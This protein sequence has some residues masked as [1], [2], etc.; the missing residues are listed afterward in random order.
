VSYLEPIRVLV[1]DDEA[2][3][4]RLAEK[5]LALPHREIFTARTASQAMKLV[6]NQ[7]FDV[8]LLDIRLPDGDGQDLLVKFRANLPNVEIIMITGY[9][10]VSGA[11]EA[12]KVGAYDY[13]TKPFSL[14]K[15]NS[16]IE[17]AYQQ[18]ALQKENKENKKDKDSESIHQIIG[19]SIAMRQTRYLIKKVAKTK[20][21]VLVT[22]ETGVGKDVVVNLIHNLSHLSEKPLVVKNCGTFN[23]DLLRNELFGH[24]KGSFT[25]AEESQ[26]GLIAAADKSSLFLDEIGEL[27]HE[28]QSML[29]RI[30]E[31]KKYRRVGDKGERQADVRFFFATN[32]DLSVEVENGNFNE[33]LFHRINV[34]RIDVPP[35]RERKED[36]PALIEYFLG[37]LHPDQSKYRMSKDAWQYFLK[38]NW[39]GNVR[40]LKNVIERSIIL[41]ENDLITKECLPEKMIRD[42]TEGNTKIFPPLRHKEKQYILQVLNHTNYNKSLAADMLGIGR[43]TL[44]RKLKE[45]RIEEQ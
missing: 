11:V 5:E 36:L 14:T 8:I 7:P 43:K 29:L 40:E 3:I 12:M 41:A 34:F 27:S 19:H 9:S 26:E 22:G 37:H 28:L 15:I 1:V 25:G 18:C 35:L 4:C 31:T 38:Y 45:Y 24:K 44:Y 6:E 33:A 42:S 20:T 10:E 30:L 17:E 23:K 13:I 2:S 16:V 21:P 32:K 39:P